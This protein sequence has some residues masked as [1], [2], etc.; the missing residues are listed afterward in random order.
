MTTHVTNILVPVDFSD[1]SRKAM[2]SAALLALKFGA[3]LTAAHIVPSFGAFNYSFPGDT[4]EFEKQVFA[5]ARKQ[6]PEEIPSAYRD[7]L[8]TQVIVKAGDI[9][10]ELLGIVNDEN[11]DLV[12]MGT[13]GRRNF[14]RFF[15]GS[16][17]EGMLRHLPV[18]VLTVSTRGSEKQTESPFEV[19][20][21][22]ILYA[23]DL[24]ET[25]AAGLHY[26]ADL[27]H[28][29]GAHL[30]L[31]H[32]MDLHDA[33]TFE[34][35]ADIHARLMGRMHKTVGKE[36]CDGLQIATEVIN[37]VPHREILRFAEKTNAD[38]IVINLQSKGLLERAL[39]GSTAERVIRSSPIPV[40]CIPGPTITGTRRA[41]EAEMATFH[42]Q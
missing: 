28:V 25:T 32:V 21:R 33:V 31:L 23:T 26:C 42:H 19:P 22:R 30:T 9:R 10:D 3:K 41:I 8:K 4:F 2:H 18:P 34:S 24:S 14:Q 7:Q 27:A 29:L 6:L 37:G 15:L 20:F 13:H 1:A 35:E 36:R 38:L 39:L 17:T 12:V 16:T 5:E 40:L 11:I